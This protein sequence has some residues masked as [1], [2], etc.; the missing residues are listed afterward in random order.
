M[1]NIEYDAAIRAL[2]YGPQGEQRIT[3]KNVQ[4]VEK[5]IGN[6][7]QLAAYKRPPLKDVT[8]L[9]LEDLKRKYDGLRV[10]EYMHKGLDRETAE[11]AVALD[12]EPSVLSAKYDIS[13]RIR[14]GMH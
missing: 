10:D 11:A 8:E 13:M 7:Q 2:Q 12:P 5:A 9:L 6:F 4:K 14:W 3:K 1:D